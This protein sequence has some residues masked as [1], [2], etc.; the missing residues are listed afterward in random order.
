[1]KKIIFSFAFLGMI[2]SS[3]AQC[4][5]I[6]A[7]MKA[8][9]KDKI[10]EA[11]SLFEKVGN[12]IINAETNKE[13]IPP[14]CYAKYYYGTG[15]TIFQEYLTQPDL[16]LVTKISLLN[17][18][19]SFFDKFFKLNFEDKSFKAKAITDLEAVANSQKEVAYDYFQNGDYETAFRLF[20]KCL[21]N[22][23]KIG[24]KQPDLHAYESAVITASR[25]G[26]F[27]KALN[28]NE[29]LINNPSL[30]IGTESN[31]QDKNLIRKAELLGSLGRT[32]EALKVLDSAKVIF[33]NNADVEL[34]Q[35]R[36]LLDVKDNDKA[37]NV[38]ESLTLKVSNRVDLF[39]IMG[40]IYS[41]KRQAD[42]SYEAYK[43]A[44]SIDSESINALYGMG[45]Y[46]V[47]KSNGYVQELNNLT[48]S[49]DNKKARQEI[50]DEMNKNFDKAIHYF[51]LV[52]KIDP[53]DQST[54]IA[55]K[56]IYEMKED[57]VNV[58]K[59]NEKII[60]E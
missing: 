54:L 22:K 33:P 10:V 47:N 51:D 46:Y 55:L 25:L 50:I 24:Q 48:L 59:I 32:E 60:A 20:E 42:K 52:L 8:L 49:Q 18:A 2:I 26:E 45:A 37:I 15:A 9:T 35:L 5:S 44:L 3:N 19:E 56:K 29:V 41:E 38:L 31:K 28:Y 16:D 57:Q 7:G 11:K 27:D 30:K 23:T 36:I 21:I 1:M 43:K 17:K 12:E 14:K 13:T 53:D 40:Q 39:L 4:N 6:K 58:E 34:Q